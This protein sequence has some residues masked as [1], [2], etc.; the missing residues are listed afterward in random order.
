MYMKTFSLSLKLFFI[1]NLYKELISKCLFLEDK[2]LPLH[3]V[4]KNKEIIIC[5]QYVRYK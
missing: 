4:R 2:Q 5:E 1:V 3:V